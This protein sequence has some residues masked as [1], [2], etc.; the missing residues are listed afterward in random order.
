MNFNFQVEQNK[1]EEGEE[2][3]HPS[4]ALHQQVQGHHQED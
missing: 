1:T 3:A 4:Q 2:L